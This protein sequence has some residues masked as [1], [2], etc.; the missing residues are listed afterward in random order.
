VI[1][2]VPIALL[3]PQDTIRSVRSQIDTEQNVVERLP[4]AIEREAS[5]DGSF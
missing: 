3:G 2:K 1:E 5:R 4:T